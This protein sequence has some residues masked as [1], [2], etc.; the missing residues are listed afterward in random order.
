MSCAKPPMVRE[1][2]PCGWPGPP[3]KSC[4]GTPPCPPPPFA[5]WGGKEG[6]REV[7]TSF[8]HPTRRQGRRIIH[9][10]NNPLQKNPMLNIQAPFVGCSVEGLVH[11]QASARSQTVPLHSGLGFRV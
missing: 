4:L 2:M 1:F 10:R 11:C 5:F 8:S 7:F 3:W 6:K 9:Y